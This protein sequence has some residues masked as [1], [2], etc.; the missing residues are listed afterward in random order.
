MDKRIV[1]FGRSGQFGSGHLSHYPGSVLKNPGLAGIV[2]PYAIYVPDRTKVGPYEERTHFSTDNQD[3]TK[4]QK[5]KNTIHIKGGSSSDL[6]TTQGSGSEEKSCKRKPD[7]LEASTTQGSGSTE[8]SCECSKPEEIDS[9]GASSSTSPLTRTTNDII[10]EATKTPVKISQAEFKEKTSHL[11]KKD[12]A[13]PAK[14]K[15]THKFNLV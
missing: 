6:A 7:N 10:N 4:F 9:A 2:Q 5:M 3:P 12:G 11:H 8:K 15:R 13:T 1:T 14:K